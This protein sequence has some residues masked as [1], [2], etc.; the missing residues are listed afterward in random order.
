[1]LISSELDDNQTKRISEVGFGGMLE[2]KYSSIHEKLSSWLVRVFDTKK[3]ELVISF[4]GSIKIDAHGVFRV[5]GIPI[6]KKVLTIRRKAVASVSLNST[7]CWAVKIIK[8]H[9]HSKKLKGCCFMIIRISLIISGCRFGFYMQ[10]VLFFVQL[11][12]LFV[13]VPSMQSLKS[14]K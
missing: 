7:N 1:M 2:I 5:F 14:K 8:K 9:Q 12:L 13:S 4:R 6:G 3:S 10:S 11:L